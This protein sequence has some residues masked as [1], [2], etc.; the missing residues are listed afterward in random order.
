MAARN[1]QENV[2]TVMVNLKMAAV[3][4]MISPVMYYQTWFS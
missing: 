1:D 2:Q 3:K 4:S